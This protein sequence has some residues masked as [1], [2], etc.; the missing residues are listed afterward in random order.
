[1]RK[2]I[3]L[4]CMF[5]AS[6]SVKA[7][8]SIVEDFPRAGIESIAVLPVE[9][10]PKDDL[11]Q[12][13]IRERVWREL[14]FKGYGRLP[15]A[16]VSEA[17]GR[18]LKAERGV[19]GKGGNAPLLKD[20][21][22]AE[23]A[24]RIT[25]LAANKEQGFLH[26]KMEVAALFELIKLDTGEL[27]WRSRQR[28]LRICPGLSEKGREMNVSLI[29]EETIEELARKALAHLPDRAVSGSSGDR[30]RTEDRKGRH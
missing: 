26:T 15:L 6:C 12:R 11:I 28:A 27:L 14:Y 2:I 16:Q 30:E 25:L 29:F 17:Y 23:A 4:V 19:E 18:Y 9:D 10:Q 7:P 22:K 5:L 21:L 13:I 24:M 1:M 20:L 8:Y 3:L